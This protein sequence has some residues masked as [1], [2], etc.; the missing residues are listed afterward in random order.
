MG[1]VN[2]T[3][4]RRKVSGMMRDTTSKKCRTKKKKRREIKKRWPASDLTKSH[5]SS[6]RLISSG[7]AM[8]TS[9]PASGEQLSSFSVSFERSSE[10]VTPPLPQLGSTLPISAKYLE[11]KEGD[12]KW[13]KKPG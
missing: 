5:L 9:V 3:T 11:G 6:R 4:E 8:G 10:S 7:K 12:D 1:T 13:K 2:D